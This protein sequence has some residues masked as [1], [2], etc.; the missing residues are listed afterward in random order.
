MSE[1]Q[2]GELEAFTSQAASPPVK[3]AALKRTLQSA[4]EGDD[5]GDSQATEVDYD[6]PYINLKGGGGG[7]PLGGEAVPVKKRSHKKGLG[8][9]H[10]KKKYPALE[11]K[12]PPPAPPRP[13]RATGTFT[14]KEDAIML[15][16]LSSCPEKGHKEKGVWFAKNRDLLLKEVPGRSEQKIRQYLWQLRFRQKWGL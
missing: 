16:I 12:P 5:D 6:D 7:R 2:R 11:V 4:T 8:P 15:R 10:K 14:A 1:S 3:Q 9:S 13:P